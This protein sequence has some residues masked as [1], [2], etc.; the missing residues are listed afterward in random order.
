MKT[1]FTK[2]EQEVMDLIVEAHNKFIKL[3]QTHL[4]DQSDWANGIH[5][6]QKVLQSRAFR[7]LYPD[8]FSSI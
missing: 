3:E 8:V 2:E 1:P 4:S 6:C 5:S 7:R